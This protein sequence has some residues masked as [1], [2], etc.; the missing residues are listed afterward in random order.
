MNLRQHISTHLDRVYRVLLP[1]GTWQ[2]GQFLAEFSKAEL[3]AIRATKRPAM[4]NRE[5]NRGHRKA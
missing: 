2:F 5:L 4:P 1:G 3:V